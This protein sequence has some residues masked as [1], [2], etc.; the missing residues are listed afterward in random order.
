MIV[1]FNAKIA[2]FTSRYD[3]KQV[4]VTV[5][6]QWTLINVSFLMQCFTTGLWPLFLFLASGPLRK[7]KTEN[8]A[9]LNNDAKV[10]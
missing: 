4:T 7:T 1:M 6:R 2:L 10:I 9:V 3:Q 8:L 5:T